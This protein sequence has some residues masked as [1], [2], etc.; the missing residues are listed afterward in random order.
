[1]SESFRHTGENLRGLLEKRLA[2][3]GRLP[4]ERVLAAEF[5]ISRAALRK[6]LAALEMEGRIWRHVGRGTFVGPRPQPLPGELASVTAVTNPGEIME[7]RLTLEPKLAAMAAVR[8]T[9][10]ELSEME[11]VERHS[12]EALKTDVFEHW[13][14][15]LHQ[16]IARATH[17]SLLLSLFMIIHKVRQS[18]V[19]G[20]LKKSTL[21]GE[22]RKLYLE[23][24]QQLL[25]ALMDRD[26]AGAEKRMREHLETVRQHLLA[27]SYNP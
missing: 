22:N 11:S 9:L 21:T 15:L 3:G 23:Q 6:T 26:A 27:V 20:S 12:R 8:A 5:G 19:W 10:S 14:E 24:H 17:N 16:A 13:D 18:H 7:T 2:A 25:E 1:M 4:P